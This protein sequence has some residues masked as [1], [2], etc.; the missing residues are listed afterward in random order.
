MTESTT[1]HVC[2]T[3]DDIKD[4]LQF[5]QTKAP[6][7]AKEARQKKLLDKGEA[8]QECKTTLRAHLDM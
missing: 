3:T 1:K 2:V 6:D 4:F 5:L 8:C 7:E